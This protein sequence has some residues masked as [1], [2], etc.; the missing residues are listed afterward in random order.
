MAKTDVKT[1]TTVDVTGV[2]LYLDKDEAQV[3]I[4]VLAATGGDPYLS[5]RKHA[6]AILNALRSATGLTY[7]TADVDGA[8]MFTTGE[9]VKAR[10]VFNDSNTFGIGGVLRG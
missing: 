9:R 7:R 6:S 10:T 4:D 1:K 5:R 2:T 8:V 3:L